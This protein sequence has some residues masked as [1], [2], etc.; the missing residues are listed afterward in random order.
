[1]EWSQWGSLLCLL[2]A[3]RV[4]FGSYFHNHYKQLIFTDYVFKKQVKQINQKFSFSR[5][6]RG[7]KDISLL[8]SLSHLALIAG[9]ALP[10]QGLCAVGE[11]WE[12]TLILH[13]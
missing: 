5:K 6:P 8:T 3:G 4:S 10:W 7:F 1:M 12:L 13:I 11:V 2:V 9:L